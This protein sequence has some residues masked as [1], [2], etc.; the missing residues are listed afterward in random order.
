MQL[1]AWLVAAALAQASTGCFGPT[2]EQLGCYRGCSAEKDACI[3]A[4]T[5]AV[6]IR[7]CDVR[8]NRCSATCQ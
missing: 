6:Q 4:A 5:N 3:L 8:S 1:R 7:A 2:E